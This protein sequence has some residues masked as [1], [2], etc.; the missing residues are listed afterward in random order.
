MHDQGTDR[1]AVRMLT[2]TYLILGTD[3]LIVLNVNFHTKMQTSVYACS[4]A[5]MFAAPPPK[6]NV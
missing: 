3:R 2:Y 6:K 1:A 5:E 4:M